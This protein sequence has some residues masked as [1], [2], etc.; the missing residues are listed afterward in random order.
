MAR[1]ANVGRG[2]CEH[3]KRLAP[4]S[5]RLVCEEKE[6]LGLELRLRWDGKDVTDLGKSVECFQVSLACNMHFATSRRWIWLAWDVNKLTC[7]TFYKKVILDVERKQTTHAFYFK[8]LLN[9]SFMLL[10]CWGGMLCKREAGRSGFAL[11]KEEK[12]KIRRNL[13]SLHFQGSI[14]CNSGNPKLAF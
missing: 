12:V 6:I 2:S 13:D 11:K 8:P 7:R 9:T 3:M 10:I 5:K 4:L 1:G 14:G